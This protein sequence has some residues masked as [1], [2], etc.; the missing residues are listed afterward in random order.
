MLIVD[1]NDTNRRILVETTRNWRMVPTAA[2]IRAP[3]LTAIGPPTTSSAPRHS[4]GAAHSASASN[5]RFM[6][7]LPCRV[8][9]ATVPVRS[10]RSSL[11]KHFAAAGASECRPEPGRYFSPMLE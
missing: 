9:M 5:V 2:E 7:R 10:R 4:I 11:T 6:I 1:D 3:T 8:P